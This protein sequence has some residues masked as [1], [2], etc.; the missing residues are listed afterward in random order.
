MSS[1]V[2]TEVSPEEAL[3]AIGRGA[4]LVDVREDDEWDAGHT[5]DA[6]HLPLA[7]VSANI[8]RFTGRDV[9]TVCRS[10]GRSSK[11]AQTLASAGVKVSN[12]TGGMTAWA[13]AGLPVVRSDGGPGTVS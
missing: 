1:E 6:E 10:G 4:V 2:I 13:A 11:A 7:T 3:A 8:T 9:L 5:P 12:L